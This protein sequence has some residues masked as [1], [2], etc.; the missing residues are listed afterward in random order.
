MENRN[1][2]RAKY[3]DTVN[4]GRAN[5]RRPAAFFNKRAILVDEFFNKRA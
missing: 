4:K 5:T 2:F 1:E 3:D